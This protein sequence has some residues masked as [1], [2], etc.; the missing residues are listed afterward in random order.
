MTALERKKVDNKGL[1]SSSLFNIIYTIILYMLKNT[2]PITS[3]IRSVA[4]AAW[5]NGWF[6]ERS[7]IKIKAIP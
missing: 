6:S 4:A 5:S 7:A 2:S 3:I 1:A